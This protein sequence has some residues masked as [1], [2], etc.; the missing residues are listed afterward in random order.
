[1]DR[2][3]FSHLIESKANEID[4]QNLLGTLMTAKQFKDFQKSAKMQNMIHESAMRREDYLSQ[5]SCCRS[6]GGHRGG[7]DDP[8]SQIDSLEAKGEGQPGDITVHPD[9]IEL[10]VEASLPDLREVQRTR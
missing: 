5:A 1:M 2:M 4:F 6:P 10:N 7:P 8:Y 3:D 9:N